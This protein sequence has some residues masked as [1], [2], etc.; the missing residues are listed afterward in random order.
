MHALATVSAKPPIAPFEE[1]KRLGALGLKR[2][3]FAQPASRSDI[4][5]LHDMLQEGIDGPLAGVEAALRVQESSPHSIWSVHS[6]AGLLGGVAFLPLNALGLYQLIYGKLDRSNPPPE[7]IAVRL[8]RPVVLYVWAVV[9]RGSGVLGLTEVLPQLETQRFAGVDIWADPV[10]PEG[11]RLA[12][13]FGLKQ[14]R[15]GVQTFYKL[16]RGGR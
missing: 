2:G 3:V 12:Q 8:E 6:G 9:A 1:A 7:S 10:T 4:E 5:S 16:D 11:E 15:H 13:R 14:V